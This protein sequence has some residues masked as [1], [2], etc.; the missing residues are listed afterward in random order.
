MS[1]AIAEVRRIVK[2]K[3]RT[4]LLLTFV[5]T[6]L[7]PTLLVGGERAYDFLAKF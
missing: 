5:I 4:L 3:V 2:N 7:V 6:G 1:V